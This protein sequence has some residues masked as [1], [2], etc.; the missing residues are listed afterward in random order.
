MIPQIEYFLHALLQTI[1]TPLLGV[2]MGGYDSH[3]GVLLKVQSDVYAL[4]LVNH[5]FWLI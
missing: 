1:L 4:S 3:Y 5:A 2:S